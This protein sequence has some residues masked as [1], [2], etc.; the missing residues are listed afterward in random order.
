MASAVKEKG[1]GRTGTKRMPRAERERQLLDL[2]ERA[3][4]ERGYHA[5][6][7]QEI[8]SAAGV[9][10]PIIY[11]YFG[12]KEG[13]YRA[14]IRRVYADA[15]DRVEAAAAG[16]GPPDERVRRVTQ[17]VF[18]WVEE[19]RGHWPFLFGA[20]A[21]GGGVGDEAA[22]ARAGMVALIAKFLRDVIPDP[23]AEGEIE[24]LAEAAVAVTTA[25]ADRWNRHPEEPRELQEARSIRILLPAIAALASG[26]TRDPAA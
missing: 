4:A 16:G 9:T 25:L 3:F 13:L 22:S 18:G 20:Q 5:V 26:E 6:S 19:Y 21:L 2:A 23:A 11:S 10:K 17:A 8:A 7:M 24:P 15:V 1:S 12:S 14:G